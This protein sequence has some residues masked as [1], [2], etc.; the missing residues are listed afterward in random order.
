L[1]FSIGNTTYYSN[2]CNSKGLG[3]INEVTFVIVGLINEVTF[4]IVGLI[5]EVTFVIVC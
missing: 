4:V 3:L 2:F 1:V 5:M